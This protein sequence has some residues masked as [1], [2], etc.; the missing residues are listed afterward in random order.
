VP[1]S[2]LQVLYNLI[3][4][5]NRHC[6]DNAIIVRAQRVENTVQVD[7][8]DHGNGMRPDLI[9]HAFESGV[10]GDAGSGLGL[11]LC[12][13]IVEDGGGTIALTSVLGSGTTVTFTLPAGTQKAKG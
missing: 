5:A 11:A 4:N 10:S 8:I 13:Q 3:A 1:D 9:E 12:R 2:I 7:V 6:R